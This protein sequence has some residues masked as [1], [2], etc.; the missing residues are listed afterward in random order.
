MTEQIPVTVLSGYLGAGKTTLLNHLLNN[1][2]GKN[3]AILVNDMSEVNIDADLIEQ[4]SSFTRT[5][6]S[7]VELSNGCIC[8]T[9]REDLLL[10][11]EKLSAQEGL[12]AII[13]ESTGISEPIPVAQTFT[14]MDDALGIQLSD[15]CRLDTMVTVVDAKRF[16]DDYQ[17]GESLLDRKEAVDHTDDRD[18]AD[19]LID[20]IEFCDVLLLNK[21]DLLKEEQLSQLEAF[22]RKVQPSAKLIRTTN[23]AV[24]IDEVINTKRFDFEQSLHHA[25]WIQELEQGPEQHTPET[26]EYGITSFVYR[27]YEPFHPTRFREWCNELPLE[28]VR[29]KGFMYVASH[30]DIAMTMSQAGSTVTIAPQAHWQASLPDAAKRAAKEEDPSFGENWHPVYGDRINELVFIGIEMD[31]QAIR[32]SLDACLMTEEEL[33]EPFDTLEAYMA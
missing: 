18:V 1:R 26:E 20:Q 31:E 10:A 8:C 22:L 13:I 29:A 4:G 33:A 21:C 6:E 32:A 11:V 3:F 23:S 7:F 28:V 17:S 14:Y 9:L 30:Y 2:E 16:W 27:A 25:G 24:E 19:L 15:R 5:E 12:D